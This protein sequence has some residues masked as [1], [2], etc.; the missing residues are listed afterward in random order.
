MLTE[1]LQ[2]EMKCAEQWCTEEQGYGELEKQGL[3]SYL[4]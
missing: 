1:D 4:G 2:C 3:E